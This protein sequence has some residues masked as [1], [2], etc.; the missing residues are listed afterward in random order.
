MRF[1]GRSP[2]EAVRL[3]RAQFG[4]D[5][6]VRCWK[7]RRGGL[8]G[9]FAKEIFV[10][11]IEAPEGI[12]RV[13]AD[14]RAAAHRSTLA[15]WSSDRSDLIIDD[16]VWSSFEGTSLAD[17][18]ESTKDEVT[19]GSTNVL[20]TAFID[21][22]AQAQAALDFEQAFK[23]MDPPRAPVSAPAS[24]PGPER[25]TGLRAF[26]A[27]FGIPSD[28][29]PDESEATLDGLVRSFS[30]L[31]VARALPTEAGSVVVVVGTRRDV[32]ATA[33]R[34]VTLMGL[35]PSDFVDAECTA[36]SRQRIMR[37]TSRVTVV[38]V[39]APL[40]SRELERVAT[41]MQQLKPDYVVGAVSATSKRTDVESWRL[42]L[43]ALDALALTKMGE[44]SSP[45]ELLGDLPVLLADGVEVSA[46]RWVAIILEAL[47]EQ[48]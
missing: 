24:T 38:A 43:P 46:L 28:Y 18:V 23:D 41:W 6:P 44:T 27:D 36:V 22:L 3:A 47:L 21:V 2:D 20:E 33:Q 34:L 29:W 7:A 17:L 39:E 35:D 8:L 42:R 14:I 9:F 40:R 37:R 26:V 19:L 12:A 30:R 32:N 45:G 4:N 13:D 31:P 10:A 16:A 15:A 5:A 48:G 1:E 25:I 11:G